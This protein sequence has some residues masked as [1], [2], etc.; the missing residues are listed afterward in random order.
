M[1][2]S[3]KDLRCNGMVEGNIY[4]YISILPTVKGVAIS[5]RSRKWDFEFV[6]SSLEKRLSVG[7][8]RQSTGSTAASIAAAVSAVAGEIEAVEW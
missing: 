8:A 3:K 5:K 6:C 7:L 2:N 1:P 4:A